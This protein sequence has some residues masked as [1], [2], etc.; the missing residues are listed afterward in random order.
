MNV[1]SLIIIIM[2]I[3]FININII[4]IIKVILL[5]LLLNSEKSLRNYTPFNTWLLECRALSVLYIYNFTLIVPHFA[6]YTFG[7]F[8]YLRKH[9]NSAYL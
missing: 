8:K 2:I 7:L 1:E 9:C 3:I 6:I 5:M 4:V